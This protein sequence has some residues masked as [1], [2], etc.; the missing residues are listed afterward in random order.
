M[1]T[2]IK[3]TVGR[4]VWYRPNENDQTG[5]V[6]MFRVG[7]QPLMAHVTAVWSER[8]VNL[9]V[10]DSI[11]RQFQVTSVQLLQPGDSAPNGGRFAAWPE[12]WPAN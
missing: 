3:P 10:T 8:M 6:P 9:L 11:G 4:M 5:P 7:D 1:S 12:F 2:V